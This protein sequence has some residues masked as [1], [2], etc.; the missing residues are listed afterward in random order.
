MPLTKTHQVL[1]QFS[2]EFLK[3]AI[4]KPIASE[5]GR[6]FP[7]IGIETFGGKSTDFMVRY[8]KRSGESSVEDVAEYYPCIVIQDFMPEIDKSF[9]WGRNWV[10]GVYDEFQKKR[11][12]V[13]LPIPM[14]FKFQVSAVTKRKQEQMA[15]SDWFLSRFISGSQ[16]FF[17]F[18]KFESE[19]GFVGD[20]VPY[21]ISSNEVDRGDGR[22]EIAYDF[23]LK[24][25]IHTKVKNFIFVEN[26]GF[27]GGDFQDTLEKISVSLSMGNL[28][29][30]ETVLQHKIEL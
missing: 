19:E 26:Q 16:D 22:F 29:D 6:I 15:V 21:T 25:F 13:F 18:N 11:E 3:L 20:V 5:G 23:I 12:I 2:N 24:T 10:E 30:L 4:N 7:F 27:V 28:K 1:E 17:T 8:Y 14:E 9:K